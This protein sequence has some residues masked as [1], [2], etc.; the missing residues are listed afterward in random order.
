MGKAGVEKEGR[1]EEGCSG[2][3]HDGLGGGGIG[4]QVWKKEE[5]VVITRPRMAR[6]GVWLGLVRF[7]PNILFLYK[8]SLPTRK[9]HLKIK[10]SIK[11]TTALIL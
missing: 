10:P 9:F 4:G 7:F 11:L 6:Q 5:L 2:S 1:E 3:S 8:S